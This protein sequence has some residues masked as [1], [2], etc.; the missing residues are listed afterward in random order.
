MHCCGMCKDDSFNKIMQIK[1]ER[2]LEQKLDQQKAR[3]DEFVR[4]LGKWVYQNI[5]TPYD[6]KVLDKITELEEG[7]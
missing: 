2:E 5:P 1:R 7:V 6:D 3:H 4:E